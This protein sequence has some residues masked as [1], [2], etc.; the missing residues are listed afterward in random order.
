MKRRDFFKQ[1]ALAS[2]SLF[3]P[4]FLRTFDPGRMWS[5]RSGKVLV[6]I[7]L[8]GGN[9]GLNTFVPFQN[10]LYY[11]NRPSLG[12]RGHE[13]LKVSD[14]MGLNPGMSALRELWDEGL[15]SVVNAVGYPNPDRSH[16]RSMDIWHTASDSDAYL[17]TGWLGRYLDNNCEG[18]A[19]PHHILEIDDSLSLAL[20]GEN[21]NGF[22]MSDPKRLAK[23]TRNPLL[24][25]L[26]EHGHAYAEEEP[27]AY[28]Y[29][30]MIDTQQSADYLSSQA[31]KL[32]SKG[33]Y[34]KSRFGRDLKR[35]AELIMADT[36]TRVYYLTLSGFD[37]HVNQKAVHQRLLQQYAE[38]MNAF[39]KDLKK[40]G[41]L[42]DT[43]ILTFSEFGRRVKQNGSGGTDHGTA[44]N[45]V[46]IGGKL[47][48]PGFFND[49]PNLSRLDQGDLIYKVD[50]R[51]IYSE[52]LTEWLRSDARSILGQNF[53]TPG[54]I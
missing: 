27:A 19:N 45:V 25:A 52:I 54:L 40:Q 53:S 18:C 8:S 24:E 29:K 16:F 38:G 39:V 42:D 15:V 44:N 41:L 46:L 28:L 14:E 34:P 21:R 13:V 32:S 51:E 23:T 35:V 9:D 36:D 5:S 33:D 37:T 10:D 48:Q 12:I 22:A 26:G 2:T 31:R 49:S 50:F 1:S 17:N 11:Q 4:S 3:V 20:K 30:V 7:Q 43:L 47:R 6:L